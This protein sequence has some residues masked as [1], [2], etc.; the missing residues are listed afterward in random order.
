M[1]L[2]GMIG[3]M[4]THVPEILAES[5]DYKLLW[6]FSTIQTGHETGAR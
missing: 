5:D 2:S 3:G 1:G 6:D 4:T